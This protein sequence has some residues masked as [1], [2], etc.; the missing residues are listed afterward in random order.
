MSGRGVFL[1]SLRSAA[2]SL[3]CFATNSTAAA[4]CTDGAPS[5]TSQP[6]CGPEEEERGEGR[7]PAFSHP[8]AEPGSS[9]GDCLVNGVMEAPPSPSPLHAVTSGRGPPRL[10]GAH[11]LPRAVP[12]VHAVG[13][14]GHVPPVGGVWGVPKAVLVRV[15]QE[16]V[17]HETW[18]AR[19]VA[20]ACETPGAR[21]AAIVEACAVAKP[22]VPARLTAAPR[23]PWLTSTP[24]RSFRRAR[25][26]FPPSVYPSVTVAVR[27]DITRGCGYKLAGANGRDGRVA[28]LPCQCPCATTLHIRRAPIF[29]ILLT[30]LVESFSSLRL[31]TP[32]RPCRAATAVALAC[33]GVAGN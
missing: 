17:G 26:R 23:I 18:G 24:M 8:S 4:A 12:V 16:V 33:T 27:H 3:L 31:V 20:T 25:K 11:S 22:Q 6:H 14:R 21:V 32:L 10:R 7:S 13:T 2:A 28:V 9:A 5:S 30:S 1:R 19:V 15:L 29:T